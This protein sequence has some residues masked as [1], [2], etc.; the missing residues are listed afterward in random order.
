MVVQLYFNKDVKNNV[1]YLKFKL[2]GQRVFLLANSGNPTLEQGAGHTTT[3]CSSPR[4]AR[5]LWAAGARRRGL[6]A[7]GRR[8]CATHFRVRVWVP[9]RAAAASAWRMA[10]LPLQL[11]VL[12]AVLGA[13]LAAAA[14][15]LVRRGVGD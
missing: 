5:T 11:V 7:G 8:G 15:I 3:T 6:F 10:S 13:A 12:G 9:D 4:R 1:V 14:L 2:S